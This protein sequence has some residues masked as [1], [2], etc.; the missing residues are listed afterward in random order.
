MAHF[1]RLRFFP[2]P[3]TECGLMVI[4]EIDDVVTPNDVIIIFFW[5]NLNDM[6]YLI[7]V[8]SYI[9]LAQVE[10]LFLLGG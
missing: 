1:F 2:F 4:T 6:N 8:P 10:V 7:G 3:V 5:L 9:S